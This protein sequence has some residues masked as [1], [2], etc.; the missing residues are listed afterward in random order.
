MSDLLASAKQPTH[1]KVI[2]RQTKFTPVTRE[3]QRKKLARKRSLPR[4]SLNNGSTR[5]SLDTFAAV[6]TDI[7]VNDS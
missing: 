5:T 4:R 1:Y 2:I 6:R 7:T 3:C